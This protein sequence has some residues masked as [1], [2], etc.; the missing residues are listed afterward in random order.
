MDNALNELIEKAAS[1]GSNYLKGDVE[2]KDIPQ[3]MSE[4]GVFLLERAKVLP[5]MRND[6]LKAEFIEI[7][8]KLDDMRKVLFSSKLNIK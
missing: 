5:D 1:R 2:L 4:L 7:Q 8:N 3:K 6:K